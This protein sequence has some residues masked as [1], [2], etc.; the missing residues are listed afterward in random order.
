MG[1]LSNGV[2]KRFGVASPAGSLTFDTETETDARSATVAM[3]ASRRAQVR[4]QKQTD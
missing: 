4:R 3:R 1:K 2:L